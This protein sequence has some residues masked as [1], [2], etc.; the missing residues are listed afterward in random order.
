ML[1][2]LLSVIISLNSLYHIRIA[3]SCNTV[4]ESPTSR[5]VPF[6]VTNGS[7]SGVSSLIEK[8]V[9]VGWPPASFEGTLQPG[10]G[11]AQQDYVRNT[12]VA[13]F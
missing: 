1:P 7:E 6:L 3:V 9:S 2:Q 4:S 8:A 12:A 11:A 5:V 13:P 10:S